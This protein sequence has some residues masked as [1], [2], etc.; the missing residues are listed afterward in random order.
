MK[1]CIMLLMS[2]ALCRGE[3]AEL[4]W[5]PEAT[6]WVRTSTAAKALIAKAKPAENRR[7]D[8]SRVVSLSPENVTVMTSTGLKS[9]PISVVPEED[10]VKLGITEEV[11][12]AFA[13][14]KAAAEKQSQKTAV[15]EELAVQE[16]RLTKAIDELEDKGKMPA[17]LTIL[18]VVPGGAALCSVRLKRWMQAKT[19]V[20]AL[21]AQDLRW[22]WVSQ[23]PEDGWIEG[24]F[25]GKIDGDQVE[26]WLMP[27]G[28][29]TYET[30]GQGI[31][32]IRKYRV[33]AA[34]K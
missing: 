21:G 13:E 6:D 11:R 5:G 2:V 3:E 32:T 27:A 20:S 18:Q 19:T 34:P 1:Y 23:P 26:A 28:T 9:L 25:D 30:V 10:R 22:R 17:K 33:V 29:H 16:E 31:R 12:A 14:W 24:P 8:W 15:L 4:T 7:V